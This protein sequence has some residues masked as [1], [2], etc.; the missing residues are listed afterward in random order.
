MSRLAREHAL[1]VLADAGRT[2]RAE[3]ADI[4]ALADFM[5][6]ESDGS[7]ALLLLRGATLNG[8]KL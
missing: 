3:P 1:L 8:V 4:A 7:L 6:D 2:K 5:A